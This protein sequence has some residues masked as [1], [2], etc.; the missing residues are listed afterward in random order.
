MTNRKQP[1]KHQ[2]LHNRYLLT[3]HL[4]GLNIKIKS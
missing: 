2:I 3:L 1:V 4:N